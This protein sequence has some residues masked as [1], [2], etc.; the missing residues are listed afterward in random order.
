MVICLVNESH[1]HPSGEK[2]GVLRPSKNSR[3]HYLP[4]S[5]ETPKPALL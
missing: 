2:R 1:H 5:W 4:L 3:I